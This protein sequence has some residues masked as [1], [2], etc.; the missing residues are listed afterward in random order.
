VKDRRKEDKP[1]GNVPWDEPYERRAD[2]LKNI[3]DWRAKL[4]VMDVGGNWCCVKSNNQKLTENM[5]WLICELEKT[6]KSKNKILKS[7]GA[8]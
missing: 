5:D 4:S 1:R 6:R 8:I 7:L 3:K 2:R